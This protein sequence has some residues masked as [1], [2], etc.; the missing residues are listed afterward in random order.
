[1]LQ[2]LSDWVTLTLFLKKCFTKSH[3]IRI[4]RPHIKAKTKFKSRDLDPIFQGREGPLR[5]S[6][7]KF[8]TW[9]LLGKG[10]TKFELA[11]SQRSL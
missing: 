4:Q 1:M 5:C 10:K 3:Q 6:L 9:I 7:N 2:F 11:R 8:S